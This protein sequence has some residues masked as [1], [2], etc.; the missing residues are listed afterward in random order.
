MRDPSMRT[1]SLSP[2]ILAATL[3]IPAV[4]HPAGATAQTAVRISPAGGAATPGWIG[5]NLEVTELHGPGGRIDSRLVI[6]GVVDGSPADEARIQPGDVIARLN[7]Q[8]TDFEAFARLMGRLRPGDRFDVTLTR[9]GARWEGWERRVTL[10]AAAKPGAELVAV[11]GEMVVRLDSAI[12]RLDS[13]RVRI[14]HAEGSAAGGAV[15]RLN[16]D[17]R[18]P[19]AGTARMMATG[20]DSTRTFVVYSTDADRATPAPRVNGGTDPGPGILRWIP[21]SRTTYRFLLRDQDGPEPAGSDG[22][23]RA[24]PPGRGG[25]FGAAAARA[26]R[27][28]SELDRS[29]EAGVERRTGVAAMLEVG[30]RPLMPYI[31]GRNRVA[32][33]ELTPLNPR[34]ASY[35][36]VARGLLVTAV[37]D[38]TPAEEAGL[39][40]GDVVLRVGGIEVATLAD[41]RTALTKAGADGLALEIVRRG[42]ALRVTLPR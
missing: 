13:L 9:E 36:E 28:A 25:S 6:R 15:L 8:P 32:G 33:A 30:M 12:Q 35:F 11:P 16:A 7:G 14:A 4:S 19:L 39:R 1:R 41:L 18:L 3:A 20:P 40:P 5:I 22:T 23:A 37:T 34:L 42:S 10:R 17:S 31:A 21:E 38:G 26:G 27:A 2:L 29:A 24:E